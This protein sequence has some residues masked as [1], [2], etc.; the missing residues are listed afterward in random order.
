[1]HN[2]KHKNAQVVCDKTMQLLW[3][4][5][6]IKETRNV[7]FYRMLVRQL[8]FVLRH[9]TIKI[10]TKIFQGINAGLLL[11][12]W[13]NIDLRS[14]NTQ[15]KFRLWRV[16]NVQRRNVVFTN[17]LYQTF[18]NTSWINSCVSKRLYML[19]LLLDSCVYAHNKHKAWI[20][21]Y[22]SPSNICFSI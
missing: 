22:S 16:K 15:M 2:I 11:P 5:N 6:C 4:N 3:A 18:V 9:L 8:L 14:T 21:K 17:R 7:T 13:K 12:L 10:K 1:M 20:C 19:R